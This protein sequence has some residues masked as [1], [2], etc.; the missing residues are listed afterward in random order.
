MRSL[1]IALILTALA[2]LPAA[3]ETAPPAGLG[4]Q[5]G[6]ETS[7]P[8][9]ALWD[10]ITPGNAASALA[11]LT[12]DIDL[13][14]RGSKEAEIYR[15]FSPSVVMI[16]T[17]SGLGSGILVGKD[18][19]ILTNF[20]VV[21]GFT[22][23]G[24]VFKPKVEGE[25]PTEADIVRG[26]VVA[27]E[28]GRDLALVRV[29]KVPSG[30]KPIGFSDGSDIQVGTDVHAIG[31]PTG[32]AW[33]YT[34]GIISQVRKNYEWS[35]ESGGSFVADVIQTQ[36]PINPGNS[37]GPLLDD[38][39]KLVGVNSFVNPDAEGINYAISI[40]TVKLFLDDVKAGRA[41]TAVAVSPAKPA[42]CQLKILTSAKESPYHDGT[43]AAVDLDC[44]GRADA[45]FFT[46]Y[47]QRDPF[48][49]LFDSNGDGKTD[50]AI[51]D[52]DHD[53]CWDYSFFDTNYDGVLDIK[54]V[55][56]NCEL[57]PDRLIPYKASN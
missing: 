28:P 10:G 19:S 22:V 7:G 51:L 56:S 5:L 46:P 50:T 25:A 11:N 48:E 21:E 15:K 40:T 9:R 44:D 13:L 26:D 6:I 41:Q 53:G 57:A 27:V 12:P 20:H 34:K 55:H 17:D 8:P 43:I 2:S 16:V 1:F 49:L 4:R 37:G 3:A 31:H 30:V 39:G 32:E 38:A 14:T 35:D 54:G 24:I 42:G 18:G 45:G 52:Q 29:A 36:T 47:D 33:T 23:V